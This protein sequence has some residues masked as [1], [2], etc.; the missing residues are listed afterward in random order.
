MGERLSVFKVKKRLLGLSFGK[1]W[2]FA[3]AIETPALTRYRRVVVLI[4]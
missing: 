1:A 2:S 3:K 4:H